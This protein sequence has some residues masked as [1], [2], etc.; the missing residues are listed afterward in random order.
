MFDPNANPH[1]HPFLFNSGTEKI[2]SDTSHDTWQA[3]NYAPGAQKT[4]QNYANYRSWNSMGAR[5][6]EGASTDDDE[7]DSGVC[8]PPLWKTT[9][10]V[11]NYRNLSP[12]SRTQAI[13]RGQRELMEMVK[14]MPES[15]Y[16]LSLKDLVE[17][18]KPMVNEEDDQDQNEEE[19]DKS[20]E[21]LVR[22]GNLNEEGNSKKKKSEK[23]KLVMRSGSID[24]G[25]FLLKMVFP[26]SLGYNKKNMNK[27]S[28]N[29]N[30]N[31]KMKKSDSMVV[32]TNS[33]N[34]TSAK[35]SPKPQGQGQGQRVD[36]SVKG[37][38]ESEWWKMKRLSVSERSESGVSSIN[39]GSRKSSGSSS[40][41]SSST[42]SISSSSRRKKGGCWSFV[43]L[44]KNK[45]RD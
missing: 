25:G 37:G 32:G 41:S 31:N 3:V 16:E 26:I 38:V 4:A 10:R 43:M 17:Y 8:S 36:G 11:N 7:Y 23:K 33:N 35:V 2:T 30:N 15:C 28:N 1:E 6:N 22:R 42:R 13:A 20:T 21:V 14:N 45:R 12:A 24:S 18:K 29:N 9:S 19:G 34:S 5:I 40:I 27:I 39:S 44:K